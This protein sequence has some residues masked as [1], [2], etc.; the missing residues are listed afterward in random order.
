MDNIFNTFWKE[1]EQYIRNLYRS[2]L[3]LWDLF[4]NDPE[5]QSKR[6]FHPLKLHLIHDDEN[7]TIIVA[8][9]Y[10]SDNDIFWGFP[11]AI[12]DNDVIEKK[13]THKSSLKG[14]FCDECENELNSECYICTECNYDLCEKCFSNGTTQTVHTH[15]MLKYS[16]YWGVNTYDKIHIVKTIEY[17]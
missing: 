8:E 9:S 2:S 5:P 6:I 15:D 7:N 3:I 10:P 4:E 12:I 17:I 13:E 1:N 16:E 11:I 14:F